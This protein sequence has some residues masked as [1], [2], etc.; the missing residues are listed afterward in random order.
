MLKVSKIFEPKIQTYSEPVQSRI[1]PLE[2]QVI[3]TSMFSEC[4]QIVEPFL[5][6]ESQCSTLYQ[7]RV[8]FDL[9]GYASTVINWSQS[10]NVFKMKLHRREGSCIAWSTQNMQSKRVFS[11]SNNIHRKSLN[12][13]LEH[14]K[15]TSGQ[16]NT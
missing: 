12:D 15:V 2:V 14:F 7:I 13:Q 6:I 11:C 8:T 1:D 5:N 4:G 10:D 9:P 16:T 3:E